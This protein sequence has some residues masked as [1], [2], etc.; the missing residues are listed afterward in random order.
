MPPEP[1]FA[2]GQWSHITD[3]HAELMPHYEQAQRMLG[4]VLNP[5]FT[6]A[7][8]I[9]KEVADEMGFGETFVPAPVGVFFGPD[10]TKA[11]G[12]TVPDP[13]FGGAGPERTGCLECGS[14]MT[15][16]RYG[17]EHPGE[18]L[19]GSRGIGRRASGSDDDGDRIRAAARRDV[20]GPCRAHR[21]MAA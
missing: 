14:C 2:D 19:P 18:E 20:G 3:W 5:T 6:D 12:K 9:V 13:Y 7:D 15:G 21:P 10:G 1:F 4:V 8:C 11:P 17:A 16:C